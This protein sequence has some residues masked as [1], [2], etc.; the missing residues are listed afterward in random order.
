MLI[1]SDPGYRTARQLVQV[2]EE[3]RVRA[4]VE[5]PLVT[6]SVVVD[7][8]E[9]GALIEIDGEPAGF[10]PAVL[11]T[12]QA[13]AHRVRVSLPGYVAWETTLVVEP[14]GRQGLTAVLRPSQ[15]VT[16]AS[17]TTQAVEDAPASVTL[18]G[19]QEIRAFGYATLADALGGAR[20]IF[21]TNDRIY[22]Y[23][24]VRGFARPGDYNNRIL[25]TLDGHALNDDQ[26]GASYVGYD[27]APDLADVERIELVRGPGSALYG[28]NAFFGV[29][30]VVTR[31]GESTPPHLGAGVEGAGTAR[32][33]AGASGKLGDGGWW[34]SV[35]GAVSQGEDFVFEELAADGGGVSEGADGFAAAGLRGRLWA[36][37]FSATV[38]GNYRDKRIPTGAFETLL[39]DERAHSAD[40]RAF[41]EARFEPEILASTQ[42]FTRAYLDRYDFA[43]AYPYPGDLVE[44]RWEGSWAGAEARVVSGPL[45]WLRLTGGLAGDAHLAARLTGRDE[46]GVYLSESPSTQTAAVYAVTEADA[47]RTL[48]ASVGAR[49][50]W[51]SSVGATVNPRVALILRPAP[52]QT[53]KLLAGR[54]FRAASPYE[55][56]YNDDGVTQI[57]AAEL[58]PETVLSGEAE[59]TC[60]FHDVGSFV[61][62]AYY[63][64]IDGLIDLVD[65]GDVVLQYR[66]SEVPVQT[67]GGEAEL[68]RD[69][70]GGWMASVGVGY[71]HTRTGESFDGDELTNS[72]ALLGSVKGAAPLLPGQVNAASRLRVESGRLQ[73]D[74]ERTDAVV[75]ADLMLTGSAPAFRLDWALGVKNVLDWRYAH[76]SG[77][78]VAM[79]ALPQPGRTAYV[80]VSVGF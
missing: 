5:L 69:W 1:V 27:F 6:G 72:P 24:G 19:A 58:S 62:S 32:A 13:G 17:R 12:V 70:R 68:R 25:L 31:E 4:V 60:R 22:E 10:T 38:Y 11:P 44:D 57:A 56:Y 39:A 29:V 33:R 53:L 14:D 3:G 50:D 79:T 35:G 7:A 76:P 59:Y 54:A 55:L 64:R 52:G 46:A 47:G 16:A 15:E 30:N 63:N 9:K 77:D 34:A 37:D 45:A 23:V 65:V 36:G 43:G 78:D 75:L 66:N 42:L 26:V 51:I 41:V 71:Q 18:I 80:D 67:L 20:G 73:V 8:I 21:T 48:T 74:G 40:G 2:G 49:L 28:S 61:L